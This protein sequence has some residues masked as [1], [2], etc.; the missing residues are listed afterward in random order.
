MGMPSPF[1]LDFRPFDL[2]I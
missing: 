1:D 2:K